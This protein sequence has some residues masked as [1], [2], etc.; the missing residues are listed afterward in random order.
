MVVVL[1]ARDNFAFETTMLYKILLTSL[2][3]G[4]GGVL[5]VNFK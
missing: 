4:I 1:L 2:A 5:G 3:G